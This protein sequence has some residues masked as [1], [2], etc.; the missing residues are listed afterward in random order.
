MRAKFNDDLAR[1]SHSY[2]A[3]DV[4]RRVIKERRRTTLH[5]IASRNHHVR[6]SQM[7]K[8]SLETTTGLCSKE[9]EYE[10]RR[11][12]DLSEGKGGKRAVWAGG[13]RFS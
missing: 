1:L 6:L 3:D 10:R 9:N 8:R 13:S 4:N 12:C 2:N 7:D 11:T 5:D